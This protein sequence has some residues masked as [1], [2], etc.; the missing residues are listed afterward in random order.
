MWFPQQEV[1]RVLKEMGERFSGSQIVLDMVPEKY[2]RGI[3][4][5]LLR[6]GFKLDWGLDVSWAYGIKQ[7][8]ELEAFS[9]GL[10]VV[11]VEKGSAGPIITVSISSPAD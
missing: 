5:Q 9:S 6:I 2:T 11:G 10:K 3:W 8:L 1:A 4:K 7:P